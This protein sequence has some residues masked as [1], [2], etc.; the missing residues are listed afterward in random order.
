[1]KENLVKVL[2]AVGTA[3]FFKIVEVIVEDQKETMRS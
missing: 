2:V 3:A 1:M